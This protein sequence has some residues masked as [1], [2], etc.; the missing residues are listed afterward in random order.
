M[1][2]EKPKSNAWPWILGGLAALFAYNSGY[3]SGQ[4]DSSDVTAPAP[5]I[6]Y[7]PSPATQA[8]LE[9]ASEQVA[10]EEADAPAAEEEGAE[11]AGAESSDYYEDTDEPGLAGDEEHAAADGVTSAYVSTAA[12]PALVTTSL[13]SAAPAV[14]ADEVAAPAAVTRSYA[15]TVPVSAP[16]VIGCAENGSCYGDISAATGRAKTVSVGG[17]FRKDGTYVRGHYR[18]RPR[19]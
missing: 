10:A 3:A 13:A 17:Y 9:G 19:R 5:E 4:Q 7:S 1:K 11:L 2:D 14:D 8:Y 15:S 16:A 12:A 18:S 6:A